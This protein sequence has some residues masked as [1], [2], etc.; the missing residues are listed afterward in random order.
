MLDKIVTLQ[1]MFLKKKTWCGVNS[2]LRCK[3]LVQLKHL[4]KDVMV[5]SLHNTTNSVK[6]V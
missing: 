2:S 6:I 1:L 3:K 5:K 4:V